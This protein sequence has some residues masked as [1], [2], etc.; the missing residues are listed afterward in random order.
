MVVS[1]G[2]GTI[3]CGALA[4]VAL[5]TVRASRG[6]AGMRLR[7][8]RTGF[9]LYQDRMGD[10]NTERHSPPFSFASTWA[11]SWRHFECPAGVTLYTMPVRRLGK[12]QKTS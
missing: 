10:G 4:P 11:N 6:S 2:T 9:A 3:V 7:S 8:A 12:R 5:A 1:Y